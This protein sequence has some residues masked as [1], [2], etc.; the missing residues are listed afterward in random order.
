MSAFNQNAH[1][2]LD[3]LKCDLSLRENNTNIGSGKGGDPSKLFLLLNNYVICKK[4][5]ALHFYQMDNHICLE[6][7]ETASPSINLSSV[8]QEFDRFY[9]S[10]AIKETCSFEDLLNP[11]F[12]KKHIKANNEL[13][14]LMK[15]QEI[16]R[17]AIVSLDD[18]N[19]LQKQIDP[20]HKKEI[21]DLE[22]KFLKEFR[23]EDRMTFLT[24]ESRSSEI[25]NMMKDHPFY[26][27]RLS[28]I[29]ERYERIW[30]DL[31]SQE[32]L[33]RI[34]LLSNFPPDI[35]Q[36]SIRMIYKLERIV[37]FRLDLIEGSVLSK[38]TKL[39]NQD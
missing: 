17:E 26:G 25:F 5:S 23:L 22:G 27:P 36:L 19:S 10:V 12:L 6:M 33:E 3:K 24:T 29:Q 38:A 20:A 21:K 39:I 16:A 32:D 28:N 2:Y 8:R 1:F 31:L 30:K 14:Y 9:D 4:T 34:N 7:P 15:A 13:S 35:G 37:K 11:E 18:K